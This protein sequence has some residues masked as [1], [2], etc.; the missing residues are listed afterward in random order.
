MR[1]LTILLLS[2]LL[3]EISS[4]AQTTS[5]IDIPL[6]EPQDTTLLRPARSQSIIPYT[7][8]YEPTTSTIHI[9][10]FSVHGSAQIEV[11]NYNSLERW[12]QIIDNEDECS[13]LI[14]DSQGYY[15]INILSDNRKRYIGYFTIE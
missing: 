4:S 12:F 1:S 8:S 2:I 3:L 5:P 10:S 6:Y 7:C 15:L 9:Q 13:I 14:N 11:I